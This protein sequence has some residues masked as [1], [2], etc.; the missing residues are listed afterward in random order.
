MKLIVLCLSLLLARV[1][2]SL[3]VELSAEAAILINAD[4]G[5]VLFEKNAHVPRPPASTTKIATALYVL[6]GKVSDLEKTVTVSLEAV[7]RKTPK[8]NASYLLESDSSL[9]GLLKGEVVSLDSL[10]HGLLLLSGNDAANALAEAVSPSIPHFIAELNEY[11][12]GI[13]CT[14]TQFQNPHGY[15]DPDH[16][17][18]AFDLALM[19]QKALQI[20]T[21]CKIVSKPTY[22][23][24]AS[25]KRPEAKIKQTNSLLSPGKFYY[26]K[27]IGGKTG[28]HS[29]AGWCLVSAAAHEGRT[30][31]AVVLGCPQSSHR[32]LES[33]ALFEAA[34]AEK[35]QRRVLV[36]MDKMYTKSIPGAKKEL[37]VSL[38][39]DLTISFYP[40]EEQEYRAFLH[41][42]LPQLP[43]AKGQR[44]GEI[45]ITDG[46]GALIAKEDLVAKEPAFPTFFFA[47]KEKWRKFWLK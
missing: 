34:F 3:S 16:I 1:V 26:P 10:L 47:L 35:K 27:A 25:N 18:T 44:V 20:P 33:R 29:H 31:I 6:D 14:D 11:L 19:T 7:K 39:R 32:F 41:W 36:P 13:G 8:H 38:T 43:I 37:A 5:V 24:P 28:Y 40:A 23:L 22:V 46:C 9:M 21:F 45:R 17:T 2:S 42:D 30:L 15:H 12:R 4:T